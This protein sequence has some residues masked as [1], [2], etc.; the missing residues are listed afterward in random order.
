MNARP[1]QRAL[2]Q[3]ALY[4]DEIAAQWEGML[5]SPGKAAGGLSNVSNRS[6]GG[7]MRPSATS[8]ARKGL[9]VRSTSG[10]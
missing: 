9:T 2:S 1:P 8:R 10:T 6:R 7:L 3:L 5:Q 4:D